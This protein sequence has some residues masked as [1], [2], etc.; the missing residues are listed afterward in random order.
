MKQQIEK[1]LGIPIAVVLRATPWIWELK[2]DK[3][4]IRTTV[5]PIPLPQRF[6]ARPAP[7]P[8]VKW[9]GIELP[10]PPPIPKDFDGRAIRDRFMEL[11]TDEDHLA[12]LNQYGK[13]SLL[14]EFEKSRGWRRVD[15][16]GWQTVF[17]EL[18]KRA[19]ETWSDYVDSLL[20]LRPG[21]DI[22]GVRS[23]LFFGSRHEVEFH[24]HGLPQI[25][26]RGAKHLALLQASDVVSAIFATI[27]IDHLRGA[28]F[29]VC[30]R[31]DCPKF[32]EITSRHS[33]KYCSQYC[34]HLESVRR[35]R[36]R[37]R[38]KRAKSR[39][40]SRARLGRS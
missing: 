6:I 39:K 5:E 11:K 38:K 9:K 2:S 23:A 24:C 25:G 19:P 7:V 22:L 14:G 33:R 17:A 10:G 1:V 28:K 30:A 3:D 18:A 31:T 4:K 8:M 40:R 35:T 26:W 32:F 37:Q 34:A 15:F 36:G 16:E 21:F 12:F 13:F 20:P 29:G 27:E